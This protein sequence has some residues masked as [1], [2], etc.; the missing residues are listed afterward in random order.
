MRSMAH[1]ICELKPRAAAAVRMIREERTGMVAAPSASKLTDALL[2]TL[3]DYR[4]AHWGT[5]YRMVRDALR[6]VHDAV[7]A[8]ESK[9]KAKA[10]A[11]G[12]A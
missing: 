11:K 5:S 12:K 9:A 6:Q 8:V 7:T 10:A 4:A 2:R 1:E 3:N